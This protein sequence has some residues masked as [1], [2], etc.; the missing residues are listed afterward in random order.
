MA[1][2]SR[3]AAA[4]V[5]GSGSVSILPLTTC[6]PF[7]KRRVAATSDFRQHG[8][9]TLTVA[10]SALTCAVIAMRGMMPRVSRILRCSET[11]ENRAFGPGAGGSH[12]R[13]RV[14]LSGG[15]G[16]VVPSQDGAPRAPASGAQRGVIPSDDDLS[17]AHDLGVRRR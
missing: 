6:R 16:G 11:R 5:A 14:E 1:V 13:Q 4:P 3:G 8:F 15:C 2:G 9:V 7:A 12:E 10:S 17:Y